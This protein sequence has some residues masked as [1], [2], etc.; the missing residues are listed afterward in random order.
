M[1]CSVLTM[2]AVGRTRHSFEGQH[3]VLIQAVEDRDMCMIAVVGGLDMGVS[4]PAQYRGR[5]A[6]LSGSHRTSI[7][8]CRVAVTSRD[9]FQ[10]AQYCDL[11]SW[12]HRVI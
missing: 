2:S 6:S 4:S 1:N 7:L 8:G 10:A 12:T 5:N 3:S 11:E 9:R